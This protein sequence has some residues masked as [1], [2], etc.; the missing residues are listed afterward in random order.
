MI[1]FDI[2]NETCAEQQNKQWLDFEKMDSRKFEQFITQYEWSDIFSDTSDIDESYDYFLSVVQT[3]IKES[4]P[5]FN[6]RKKRKAPWATRYVKKLSKKKR[7]MWHKYRNSL[8]QHDYN[9]YKN[10]LNKFNEEKSKAI[11]NYENNIIGNKNSDMKKYY[12]YVSK[13]NKYCSNKVCMKIDDGLE[14]EDEKCAGILNNYFGTVFTRGAST[15][16]HFEPSRHIIDMQD[17]VFSNNMIENKLNML[18]TKKSSGP[19]E[20]PCYILKMFANLFAPILTAIFEKSY[21]EGKVPLQMKKSQ[22]FTSVQ[23]R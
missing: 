18:D 9:Q 7:Q 15:I 12:A 17:V 22:C 19:D 2:K 5:L 14:I 23:E 10:S 11:L 6:F 13:K 16:P 8:T 20:I 1:I 3:A 21:R 4:T